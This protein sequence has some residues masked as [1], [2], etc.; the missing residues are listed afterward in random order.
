MPWRDDF[1]KTFWV[2]PD[3]QGLAGYPGEAG[4]VPESDP[5][6]HAKHAPKHVTKTQALYRNPAGPRNPLGAAVMVIRDRIGFE[7]E[8]EVGLEDFVSI[9][10]A[11]QLLEVPVMT[12]SRWVKARRIKSAKRKGFVVI[13]LQEVLRLAKERKLNPILGFRMTVVE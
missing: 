4:T 10:E 13:Q 6:P 2:D 1:V 11:S 9:R 8:R 3:Y 7:Y 5:R 12:L